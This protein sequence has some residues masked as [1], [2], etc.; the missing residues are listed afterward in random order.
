MTSAKLP[1][2][3]SQLAQLVVW[4]APSPL[5]PKIP[6]CADADRSRT[7]IPF[8]LHGDGVAV[9]GLGKVWQK[10]VDCLSMQSLVAPR[11]GTE[12]H[13]HIL[14]MLPGSLLCKQST[15]AAFFSQL[16]R[17]LNAVATGIWPETDA[18]G[19][20]LPARCTVVERRADVV[21]RT[22]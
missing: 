9:T 5:F 7:T 14:F 1:G 19:P 2:V 17:S 21:E 6:A 15:Y 10:G 18:A 20:P 8:S 12:R 13:C 11:G 3:V 4:S 16:A 22:S